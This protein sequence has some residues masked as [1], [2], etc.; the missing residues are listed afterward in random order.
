MIEISHS[1]NS[2]SAIMILKR[3]L[4]LWSCL[5]GFIPCSIIG[6]IA[7]LIST[8]A[9]EE[10]SFAQLESVREEKKSS[11]NRYLNAISS[12]VSL[13]AQDPFVIEES[14][15][16][17]A[18]YNLL[19]NDFEGQ[20]EDIENARKRLEINYQE[21][22]LSEFKRQ[23][24]SVEAP[25]A[26]SIVGQLDAKG[27]LLQDSY[28]AKNPNSL[29][30]KDLLIKGDDHPK[31]DQVHQKIHPYLSKAR[32]EFEYYDIFIVHPKSGEVVYTVFKEV[33]FATSL[34]K[35]AYANSGLGDIYRLAINNQRDQK[36]VIRDF[37]AYL[38]SY[39]A[40][41]GFVAQPIFNQSD[42]IAVLVIQFPLG[43]L[44]AIMQERQGMGETGETYL[45]GPDKLM[46]SDSY[47]DPENHSV[48]ASFAN[49]NL[50][51][52]N[53]EAVSRV[54]N[55]QTGL[56]IVIDY[57][58]NPVL[59]AYSP[60]NA[61]GLNWAILSEIDKSEALARSNLLMQI[62]VAILAVTL[63][64]IIFVSVFLAKSIT[65][66]LGGEP[67]EL[68]KIADL[69][70]RGDLAY[71]FDKNTSSNTIYSSMAT[72]SNHL[73]DLVGKILDSAAGQAAASDQLAQ[74]TLSTKSNIHTQNQGT[75]QIADA[76]NRMN[77][78]VAEVSENTQE[79]VTIVRDAKQELEHSVNEVYQTTRDMR[80]VANF[81]NQTQETS[82][83]L[84]ERVKNI[85]VV[86]NTIRG[87]A[88]QTNLLALN[89]AIEAARAGE[90]G[91]GFAVVADEVRSLAKN[92][93][94]ETETIASIVEAL[95]KVSSQTG[96]VV[97]SSVTQAN[98]VSERAQHTVESLRKVVSSVEHINSMISQIA[99]TTE[100]QSMVSENISQSVNT[101]HGNAAQASQAIDEISSA[102]EELA[103]RANLLQEL[104]KRFSL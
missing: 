49:P 16:I 99:A 84:T 62:S 77:E 34:K 13:M 80:E 43:K 45:V 65:R 17:I 74:I 101:V 53:T 37:S 41:A 15:N 56:D 60:L 94:E 11:V 69:V 19:I 98:A 79:A 28:I 58:G 97:S 31:Y 71:N 38:P 24:P 4:M 32:A 68:V 29:G 87:I 5:M 30:N 57:N 73:K 9:L 91:R 25:S 1:N 72:M 93:R 70:A 42:M 64:A 36:P 10:A 35:G 75:A 55:G 40:P 95:Q 78:T 52:V 63:I 18:A 67:Q 26:N 81:L 39:N 96:Q 44:N 3:R 2:K 21:N 102:T 82:S 14:T 89:A 54:F 83:Q 76:I 59:S 20:P 103:E 66:P 12:Q 27:V 8:N 85:S 100:Q 88:E 50:G 7:L 22:F 48:I 92:T 6:I 47:L 86:V 104:T 23:N 51:S 61:P 90:Q 33:D 46:R